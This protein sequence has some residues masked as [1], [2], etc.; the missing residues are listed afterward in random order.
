MQIF[1]L[2]F[3]DAIIAVNVAALYVILVHLTGRLLQLFQQRHLAFA[4]FAFVFGSVRVPL[5]SSLADLRVE[6]VEVENN[7]GKP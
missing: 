7:H 4:S 3:G 2:Y 5:F 6:V 1:M